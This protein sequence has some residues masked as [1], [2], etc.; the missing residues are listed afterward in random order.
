MATVQQVIDR[1]RVPLN[2][3]DK[4]RYTDPA[5]LDFLNDGMAEIYALRPDLL[6][7]KYG[8]TPAPL[9]LTDTFPLSGKHEVSIKHYLVYRAE[10]TDDEHVNSNRAAQ[11]YKLFRESV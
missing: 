7:G 10:M 4:V 2:D 5:L 6:F 11:V 3:S 9:A 8:T 1:G